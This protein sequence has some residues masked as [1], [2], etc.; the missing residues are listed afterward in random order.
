MPN[1]N[2]S[3]RPVTADD[4]G[5]L[6]E[7]YGSTRALELALTGWDQAQQ[8]AF[9]KMQFAAQQQYYGSAFPQGEHNIILL[10]GQPVGRIYTAEADDVIRIMDITLLPA[11]RNGGIGTPIIKEVLA[12]AQAAAKPVQIYVENYNPSLRLFER[13]GFSGIQ[14]D[15]FNLLLEWRSPA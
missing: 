7:V 14:D 8:D 4:E 9:I 12:R 3:L 13:L 15:G 1:K 10:D 11:R 6:L 2:I 5:F